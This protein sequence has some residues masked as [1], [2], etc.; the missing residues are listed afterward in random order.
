MDVGESNLKFSRNFYCVSFLNGGAAGCSFSISEMDVAVGIVNVDTLTDSVSIIVLCA[1][2]L[3]AAAGG[4]CGV[5]HGQPLQRRVDEPMS[6][7][8][9]FLCAASRCVV[10][11]GICGAEPLPDGVSDTHF[12]GVR[13]GQP[14]W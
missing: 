14:S 11:D 4:I 5:I 8:S 7:R 2:T 10:A 13:R 12:Y 3:W 9:L 1:V 6:S